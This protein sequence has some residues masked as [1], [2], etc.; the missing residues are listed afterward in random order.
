[1]KKKIT[2]DEIDYNLFHSHLYSSRVKDIDLLIRTSG[3][4]RLSNFILC[5]IAYSEIY[6]SNKF[7][8]EFDENEFAKA[9]DSF[10]KRERRFGSSSNIN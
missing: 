6:Y 2:L 8:P 7:W 5:Q 4:M 1:M 3:E 10:K 9:L